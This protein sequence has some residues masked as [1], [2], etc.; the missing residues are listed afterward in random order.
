MLWQ[1]HVCESLTPC[2]VFFSDL[3][4]LQVTE[5]NQEKQDDDQDGPTSL[6]T[7]ESEDRVIR[8]YWHS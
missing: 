8:G 2:I 3:E 4:E 1:Q 6:R 5:N 7:L